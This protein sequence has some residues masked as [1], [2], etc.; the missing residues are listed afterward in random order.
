MKQITCSCTLCKKDCK[1]EEHTSLFRILGN[2][3]RLHIINALR[4]K[5]KSV[6]DII[7]IADLEQTQISHALRMLK[8]HQF[9]VC[10]RNGKE[11]VYSL[12]KKVVEPLM[13]QINRTTKFGVNI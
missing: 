13:V 8:E 5:S 6:S 11:I 9:V 10:S 2:R 3:N 12:N 1:C 4:Q 7:A